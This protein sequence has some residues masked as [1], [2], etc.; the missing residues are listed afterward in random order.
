MGLFQGEVVTYKGNKWGGL[1]TDADVNQI[2]YY[3]ARLCKNGYTT[4]TKNSNGHVRTRGGTLKQHTNGF[5][6]PIRYLYEAK[7][8]DGNTYIMARADDG[9]YKYNDTSGEF[10]ALRSP[11]G[12]GR[13]VDAKRCKACNYNNALYLTDGDKNIFMTSDGKAY[14]YGNHMVISDDGLSV[15]FYS[16]SITV[17]DTDG[18]TTTTNTAN[19]VQITLTYPTDVQVGETTGDGEYVVALEF[20]GDGSLIG[21]FF[22][23]PFSDYPRTDDF[24][25]VGSVTVSGGKITRFIIDNPVTP[26]ASYTCL[27]SNGLWLDDTNGVIYDNSGTYTSVTTIDSSEGTVTTNT[28]VTER[29][30]IDVKDELNKYSEFKDLTS[31]KNNYIVLHCGNANLIYY[32]PAIKSQVQIKGESIEGTVSQNSSVVFDNDVY[33]PSENIIQSSRLGEQ[34]QSFLYGDLTEDNWKIYQEALETCSDKDAICGA[35]DDKK[36]HYYLTIP[37][38][39]GGAKTIVYS[40]KIKNIVGHYEFPWVPTSWLI[41]EDGTVLIGC[42]DGFMREMSDDYYSDDGTA[43]ELDYWTNNFGADLDRHFKRVID[44]AIFFE[45]DKEYPDGVKDNVIDRHYIAIAEY[46]DE[47]INSKPTS[48]QKLFHPIQYNARGRGKW[49]SRR[50]TYSSSTNRI[51]LIGWTTRCEKQGFK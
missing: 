46:E 37:Q 6:N 18:V 20:Q 12:T 32:A 13:T 3:L 7:F 4:K 15:T 9:W 45:Y 48:I 19:D 23:S 42:S 1:Q 29:I 30:V 16:F 47:F 28:D 43:I 33:S 40:N 22:N 35:F 26:T 34:Y 8:E 50:I 24:F 25:S 51:K 27:N 2:S 41:K 44:A 21:K 36:Q 5:T 10:D 11:I 38:T 17:T 31:Y 49:I 39:G 14:Y